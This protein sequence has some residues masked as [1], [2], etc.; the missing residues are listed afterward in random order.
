MARS[1]SG[2]VRVPDVEC[3]YDVEHPL[4]ERGSTTE[5]DYL[6]NRYDILAAWVC[7]NEVTPNANSEL[8]RF[9][10]RFPRAAALGCGYFAPSALRSKFRD[11]PFRIGSW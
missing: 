11:S 9:I 4:G 7:D 3:N 1:P 10:C 5:C 6:A 2:L 8:S